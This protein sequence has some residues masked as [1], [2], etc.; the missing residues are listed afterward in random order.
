MRCVS[1]SV[2]IQLV[3]KEIFYLFICA[4]EEIPEF[5]LKYC[6]FLFACILCVWSCIICIGHVVCLLLW[7]KSLKIVLNLIH[8]CLRSWRTLDN[9]R[10]SNHPLHY[11]SWDVFTSESSL[12]WVGKEAGESVGPDLR[13]R[14]GYQ[15]YLLNRTKHCLPLMVAWSLETWL[16][17]STF[18]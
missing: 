4:A 1:Q 2:W 6:D 12:L 14:G 7:N 11:T 15:Q 10:K 3:K 9:T 18:C 13:L 16:K 8:F 17:C 5:K